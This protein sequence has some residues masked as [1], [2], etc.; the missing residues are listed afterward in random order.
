MR[1]TEACGDCVVS[2]LI[3]DGEI[4]ALAEQ[5]KQAIEE[6]SRVGLISPIRLVEGG[7]SSAAAGP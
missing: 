4:L 6:M 2:A 3:G 7:V 5:E 1:E